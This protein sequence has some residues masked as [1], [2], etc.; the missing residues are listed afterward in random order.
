M[1][2]YRP[3]VPPNY[4]SNQSAPVTLLTIQ[5]GIQFAERIEREVFEKRDKR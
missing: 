5:V 1:A 3:I 2:G 4:C